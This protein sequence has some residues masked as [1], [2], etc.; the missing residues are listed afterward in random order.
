MF[1][2]LTRIHIPPCSKIQSVFK[3]S[4]GSGLAVTVARYETPAHI[5]IDKV[6]LFL[7]HTDVSQK[8]EVLIHLDIHILQVGVIPD[9]PLPASFP[10]DEDG[11]CSCLRDPASACNVNTVQLFSR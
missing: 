10:K 3:L 5:D 1:K 9:R 11:F 8:V 4:D 7:T 6:S 2:F